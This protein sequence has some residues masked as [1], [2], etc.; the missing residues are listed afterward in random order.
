MSLKS[1]ADKNR[2]DGCN[3]STTIRT[4]L[5][6]LQVWDIVNFEGTGQS[7]PTPGFHKQMG[8][9]Q[10][11]RLRHAIWSAIDVQTL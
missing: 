11:S 9:H 7:S 3:G 1:R 2:S 6:N 5:A 10:D 4:P 8:A